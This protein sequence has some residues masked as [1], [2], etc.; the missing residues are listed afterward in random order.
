MIIG[1]DGNEANIRNRVGVGRYAYEL[2]WQFY[3]VQSSKLKVK[4]FNIYLKDKPLDNLP[5]ETEWW[6]Y[7][8]VGPRKLWTQVG[9]LINLF[10]DKPQ[11]DVFFTPSHYAPR[12]CPC[13]SVISVMDLSYLKYPE[14]FKPNDLWQLKNWTEYSVKKAQKILTI[15]NSSKNDIIKYYGIREDKVSVTYPGFNKEIKIIN[16]INSIKK[17]LN[18]CFGF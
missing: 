13:P 17:N 4:S 5:K 18:Y 3:K 15:S 9:F 10:F 2:L 14:L 1:I 12:F 7:K 6:K 16:N 8:I 11:P